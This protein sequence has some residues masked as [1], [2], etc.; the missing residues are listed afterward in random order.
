MRPILPIAF[1]LM[2]LSVACNNSKSILSKYFTPDNL[3]EQ[4]FT[5][6]TGQDTTVITK[7]GIKI[8]IPANAIEASNKIATL[9]IKEALALDDILRAGLTTTTGNELLASDGMFYIGTKEKSTIVKPLQV[10]LPVATADNKMQLY[11][12]VDVGG[13]ID[14]QAPEKMGKPITN[15]SDSREILFKTD[16]SSCH[17]VEAV[18][19]GPPLAWE[20]KRKPIQ[21]LRDYTRNNSKVLARGDKYACCIVNQKRWPGM[22]SFD[23]LSDWQID[24]MYRYIDKVSKEKGIPQPR[25]NILTICDSCY[26]YHDYYYRLSHARD[27]LVK[28]NQPM[29]NIDI[30]PPKD[31][32]FVKDTVIDNLVEQPQ[33]N[34]EYYQFNITAFGWLNVDAILSG[35]SNLAESNL[36]VKLNNAAT[37]RMEVFLI[38]PAYKIFQRGGLLDDNINYGFFKKDGTVN[39]LQGEN[40]I[41]FAIGEE[42]GKIYFGE[43]P[44]IAGLSQNVAIDVHE[45]SKKEIEGFFKTAHAEKVKM[46]IEK[47]KNFKGIKAIDDELGSA[48]K[49]VEACSCSY[50]RD[51]TTF[52]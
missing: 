33:F 16:C 37:D 46:S 50:T 8:H 22:M 7:Q 32:I 17:A 3:P 12:G 45:S 39:L 48:R 51:T 25:G 14:W 21:W 11:K 30:T 13:K 10:F 24:A 52:K 28:A 35:Y 9:I 23:S 6:N 26:F 19:T 15:I 1:F 34:A 40:T 20:D 18:L 47:T 29:V 4:T 42:R 41:V 44:F 31:V 49:I 2:I 27:S 43:T 36:K 5:I 38:V